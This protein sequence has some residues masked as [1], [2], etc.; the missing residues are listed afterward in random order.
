MKDRQFTV[1]LA[2]VVA[3]GLVMGLVAFRMTGAG[4]ASATTA[5]AANAGAAR[6]S[7]A[8]EQIAD[9]PADAVP[10]STETAGSQS[11]EPAPTTDDP[12]ELQGPTNGDPPGTAASEP[13]QPPPAAP[14]DG[15]LQ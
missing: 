1:I 2:L 10:P 5:A 4:P 8:D 15:T 9:Q 13:S 3:A 12:P 6:P 7:V 14:S 11:G